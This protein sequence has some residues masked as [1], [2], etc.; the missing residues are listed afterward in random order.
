MLSEQGQISAIRESVTNENFLRR[1]LTMMPG[2]MA[3]S[4]LVL[5]V[6]LKAVTTA[7]KPPSTR[8]GP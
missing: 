7:G 5:V 6:V 8:A 1:W 3:P 4:F 2:Q